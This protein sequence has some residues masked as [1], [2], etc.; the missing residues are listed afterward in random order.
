[1]VL[2]IQHEFRAVQ[3][4]PEHVRQGFLLALRPLQM[5][6][7]RDDWHQYLLKHAGK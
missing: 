6:S 1:M 7:D 2:M 5:T 4:R 3:Q